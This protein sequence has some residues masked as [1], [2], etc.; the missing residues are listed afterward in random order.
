QERC[1]AAPGQWT[2]ILNRSFS[3]LE[4]YASVISPALAS[5]FTNKFF[6]PTLL[7]KM[8]KG[9]PPTSGYERI[10]QAEDVE[11]YLE[12]SEDEDLQ[13]SQSS[14]SIPGP[15]YAPIQ[16]KRTPRM[17]ASSASS[18]TMRRNLPMYKRQR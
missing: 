5:T 1:E 9:R 2:A 10:A 12:D 13:R 6:F 15:R 4:S 3:N 7:P 17:Q 18:P 16:P 14:L 11:D 8:S